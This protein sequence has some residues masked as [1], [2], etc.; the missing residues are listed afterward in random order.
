M[1][2]D[3]ELDERAVRELFSD[4]DSIVGRYLRD[5]ADEGAGL[6]RERAPKVTGRLAGSIR[7]FTAHDGDGNT[8]TGF[9]A[10]AHADPPLAH[11]G[12]EAGM[13]YALDLDNAQGY[14]RNRGGKSVRGL[15]RFLTAAL[16]ALAGK[17]GD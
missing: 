17:V 2:D 9:G 8:Y 1:A 4:E 6:A 7:T 11:P 15:H 5:L 12:W 16:D 13:P 10:T 3:F 14:T